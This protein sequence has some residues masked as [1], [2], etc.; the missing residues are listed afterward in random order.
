MN[1]P[2]SDKELDELHIGDMV[3]LSG[4]IFCGRDAVLPRIIIDIQSGN[5][6]FDPAMLKDGVIFHTAVSPAGIGPTSSNKKEIEE[7]IIP[8]TRAGIRV[9]IGKGRIS[10]DTVKGLAEFNAI[11]AVVPPVSALLS[12]CIKEQEVVCYPELG[13]EAFYRIYVEDFPMIIASKDG[14]YIY[15]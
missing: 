2:I 15:Q 7:S 11:Y 13:M 5:N 4:N 12:N 8:L 3:Y 9:H 10:L 1:T 6:I 14:E